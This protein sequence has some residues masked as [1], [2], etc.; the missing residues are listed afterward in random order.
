[1]PTVCVDCLFAICKCQKEKENIEIVPSNITTSDFLYEDKHLNIYNKILEKYIQRWKSISVEELGKLMDLKTITTATLDEIDSNAAQFNV[2]KLCLDDSIDPNPRLGHYLLI[3]YSLS[4]PLTNQSLV[5]LFVIWAL[6][7]NQPDRLLDWINTITPIDVALHFFLNG[8]CAYFRPDENDGCQ[9]KPIQYE[10]ISLLKYIFNCKLTD[11]IQNNDEMNF[12]RDALI[13]TSNNFINPISNGLCT[14]NVIKSLLG[15]ELANGRNYKA[16]TSIFSE[17]KDAIS[18]KESKEAQAIRFKASSI[19]KTRTKLSQLSV[20]CIGSNGKIYNNQD[21]NAKLRNTDSKRFETLNR[22]IQIAENND[23][24]DNVHPNEDIDEQ[25][26][27]DNNV[28]DSDVDDNNDDGDFNESLHRN[29]SRISKLKKKKKKNRFILEEADVDEEDD[30]DEEDE[31]EEDE[32]EDD[33]NDESEENESEENEEDDY[34][35]DIIEHIDDENI[36]QFKKINTD[37]INMFNLFKTTC[38]ICNQLPLKKFYTKFTG[39]SKAIDKQTKERLGQTTETVIWL[40]KDEE[41]KPFDKSDLCYHYRNSLCQLNEFRHWQFYNVAI[42]YDE[43]RIKHDLKRNVSSRSCTICI[44]LYV[45]I[46]L[47]Q[48]A[49][50]KNA[51][52]VKLRRWVKEVKKKHLMG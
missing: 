17:T 16:Q 42:V 49:A 39:I 20:C 2:C 11:S 28:C 25:L 41:C 34:D 15:E 38:T 24:D 52:M 46:I 29:R 31:E 14:C 3:F 19:L 30:E 23:V 36:E 1:M 9:V 12:I 27:S 13:T 45:A 22:F 44:D 8:C 21:R 35:D 26:S 5:D 40:L 4:L 50:I 18:A 7:R 10:R 48:I 43:D 6:S 33:E 47:D 32:E 37:T 51:K